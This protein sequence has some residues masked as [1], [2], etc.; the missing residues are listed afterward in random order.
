MTA[1]QDC[2]LP[3]SSSVAVEVEPP[4][5]G[6][7]GPGL[8]A[9]VLFLHPIPV[10]ALVYCVTDIHPTLHTVLQELNAIFDKIDTDHS[11]EVDFDEFVNGVAK[12]VLE[13]S[14]N[15]APR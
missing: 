8:V 6:V 9:A 1:E 3:V 14:P 7:H 15:G 2:H 13:K 4:S 10:G 5:V 12:F 11:G